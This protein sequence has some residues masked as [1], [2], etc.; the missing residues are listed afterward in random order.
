MIQ[1]DHSGV[2][3]KRPEDFYAESVKPDA[4]M[5]KIKQILLNEKK[6]IDDVEERKKQRELKKYAKTVQSERLKDRAK[7]KR[8]ALDEIDRFKSKSKHNDASSSA[9]KASLSK[10]PR[11]EDDSESRGNKRQKKDEVA[12]SKNGKRLAKDAKYGRGGKK[13]HAKDNTSESSRDLS[14]FSSGKNRAPFADG[15]RKKSF[16][17][18]PSDGKSFGGKPSGGKSFGGKPSGGKSFGGKA[19]GK[20]SKGRN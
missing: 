13:R 4:H 8:D 1:L 15:P 19:G 3:Y 6:R 17:G 11:E 12:P 14:G 10:R 16:G 20:F 9:F 2:P 7:Q 18:K 5:A